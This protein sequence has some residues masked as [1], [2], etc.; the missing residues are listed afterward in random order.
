MVMLPGGKEYGLPQTFATAVPER[1]I[2]IFKA[3]NWKRITAPED[4]E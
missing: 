1:A 4:L 2:K 3:K